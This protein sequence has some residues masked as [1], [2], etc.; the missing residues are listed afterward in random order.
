[1]IL[2]M[3][4]GQEAQDIKFLGKLFVIANLAVWE[5][6][7]Q[8]WARISPAQRGLAREIAGMMGEMTENKM[9]IHVGSRS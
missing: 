8:W 2:L 4:R 5:T 3:L 1:M 7:E 9:Q 6:A